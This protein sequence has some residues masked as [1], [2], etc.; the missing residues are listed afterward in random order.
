MRSLAVLSLLLAPTPL[1]TQ[2]PNSVF[3]ATS[4]LALV[5]V[6]VLHIKT[7]TP[8]PA[9]QA[10]DFKVSEEG[11]PQEILH[12][13]R[14]E[15]P[16]SVVLLFDLTDSVRGV[17]KRLAEGAK[18]TL[19]HF[20]AADEVAVMVYSGHASFRSMGSPRIVL[21]RNR[22]RHRSGRQHDVG[23]TGSLQRGC[24][25]GGHRA[26][27]SRQPGEPARGHLAHR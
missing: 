4:E 11:V 6:Q 13:S 26:S 21:A 10:S 7:G 18:T 22:A 3:R 20:K 1:W 15:F 27:A 9:L 2:D 17:L 16:L 24:L 19:E 25:S 12:F 23:R 8:A 14:D 5:D